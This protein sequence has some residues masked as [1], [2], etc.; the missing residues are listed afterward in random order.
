MFAPASIPNI[1]TL[2]ARAA[3]IGPNVGPPRTST[4]GLEVM[5]STVLGSPAGM[6]ALLGAN[7]VAQD[8]TFWLNIRTVSI[9][10][11]FRP[12]FKKEATSV[13]GRG[14]CLEELSVL[15]VTVKPYRNAAQ[16]WLLK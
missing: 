9:V 11:V 16:H 2:R 10:T 7:L 1:N 5:V 6:M 8:A 14:R 13:G 12:C 15:S 3:R 4:S